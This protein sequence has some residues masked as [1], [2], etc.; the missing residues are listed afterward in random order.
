M[1]PHAHLIREAQQ[2]L[3]NLIQEGVF[4]ITRLLKNSET[5]Q[6][7]S[8]PT[9]IQLSSYKYPRRSSYKEPQVS[10]HSKGRLTERLISQGLL[11]PAMLQELQKEWKQQSN[12][13]GEEDK[14]SRRFRRKKRK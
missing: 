2:E 7:N 8:D 12:E 10:A 11:T 5:N 14:D 9:D 4:Q 3:D 6:A 13:I 1:F